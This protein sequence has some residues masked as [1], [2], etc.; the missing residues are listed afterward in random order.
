MKSY[1]LNPIA[2]FGALLFIS[3]IT[4]VTLASA[5]YDRVELVL[6]LQ[7]IALQFIASAWVLRD[8]KRK[9]LMW[10]ADH[11]FTLTAFIFPIYVISTRGWKGLL[12]LL[13]ILFLLFFTAFVPELLL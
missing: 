1:F 11:A 12:L 2:W 10:P 8:S 3:I 4:G 5:E 13:G 9:R 7:G 6:G